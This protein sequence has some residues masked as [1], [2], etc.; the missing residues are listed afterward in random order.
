MSKRRN[1][2]NAYIFNKIFKSVLLCALLITA[3]KNLFALRSG[4]VTLDNS[5]LSSIEQAF[6]ADLDDGEL[7]SHSYMDAFLI[8]S[9]IVQPH[10]Y[11]RYKKRMEKVKRDAKEALEQYQNDE[12]RMAEELLKWLHSNVLKQYKERATT[13]RE[14]LDKGYF[15]CLSSGILYAILAGELGLKVNG[16]SVKD[17]AYAQVH[18]GGRVYDVE[19][20]IKDGF[21]PRDDMVVG[22]AITSV[23]RKNYKFVQKVS[24]LQFLSMLYSNRISLLQNSTDNYLKDLPKYKKGYF[25]DPGSFLFSNN[26]KA[27]IK[28]LATQNIKLANFSIAHD[29]IEEGERFDA[30]DTD[31]EELRLNSLSSRMMGHLDRGEYEKALSVADKLKEDFPAY[32]SAAQNHAYAYNEYAMHFLKRGDYKRAISEYEKAFEKWPKVSLFRENLVYAYNVYGNVFLRSEEYE[33]AAGIFARGLKKLGGGQSTYALRENLK[34]AF[35]NPIVE[36]YNAGDYEQA[37]DKCIEVIEIV[38]ND[39]KFLRM[40]KLIIKSGKSSRYN[41]ALKEYRSGQYYDAQ[42]LCKKGLSLGKN[43]SL[44]KKLRALKRKAELISTAP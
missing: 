15:N 28:N 41:E 23:K 11:N 21:N 44:D 30:K 38:G 37:Y 17:H 19:T 22:N 9:D 25:F 36:L 27:C 39:S 29:Y 26:I 35:Y 13:A 24:M 34:A 31:W 1:P 43:E 10:E 2:L 14:L 20:T 33:K 12:K 42:M 40:K 5:K 6:F 32:E 4:K 3:G 8:A 18:I 7:N 16:V